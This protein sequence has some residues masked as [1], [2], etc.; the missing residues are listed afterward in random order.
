MIAL[1]RKDIFLALFLWVFVIEAATFYVKSNVID[2]LFQMSVCFLMFLSVL[3][4]G[5]RRQIVISKILILYILLVASAFVHDLA[6]WDMAG[7]REGMARLLL[8]TILFYMDNMLTSASEVPES[9]FVLPVLY[10]GFISVQGFLLQFMNFFGLPILTNRIVMEKFQVSYDMEVH[11]LGVVMYNG[12]TFLGREMLRIYGYFI[13]PAKMAS[14][15]LI[16][17]FFSWGL[18][19]KSRKKFYKYMMLLCL[20]GLILTFSRAGLIAL[21]GALIIRKMIGKRVCFSGEKK[22]SLYMVTSRKDVIKLVV[23]AVIFLLAAI[24]T[25]NL[26]VALSTFFPDFQILYH[27]ITNEQGKVNLVRKEGADIA[28]VIQLIKNKP[29]GY[30]FLGNAR[31][32]TNLANA[33]IYWLVCA[34]VPGAVL[35]IVLLGF[36][37][38]K[39]VVPALKSAE[40]LNMAA[41]SAFLALTIQNLSYGK[42]A[43][44]DFLF[45][46]GI[47]AALKR[48]SRKKCFEIDDQREF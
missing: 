19:Q 45:L 46:A 41:A 13:E 9:L 27:G 17:I 23:S 29:L 11:G 5:F 2:N 37:M 32:D 14:F 25:L 10:G 15:L 48:T 38:L 26:F 12:G 28:Y 1:R 42:W 30:G 36:I 34:G 33:F 39:L 44:V 21:I 24:L 47:L 3:V 4:K 31:L 16:P 35:S 20:I 18:Y 22:H 40:P 8:L 6:A 43:D 7:L